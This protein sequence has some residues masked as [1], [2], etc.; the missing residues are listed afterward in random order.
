[1][2]SPALQEV[3]A[4]LA[5]PAAGD[6]SQYLFERALAAAGLDWRL[7]TCDIPPER[8]ADALRG[9]VAMGFRGCLV[10]G[11]LREPALSLV[12]TASP[13]AT[14]ARAVGLLERT[15]DGF[16][17]HMTD[18]RGVI[19]AV[20]AHLDP[21]GRD[22]LILGAGPTGRAVAL[23]LALAGAAAITVADEDSARAT[24]LVEDLAAMN[25]ARAEV[26]PWAATLDLP[27]AAAIVIRATTAPLTL[28][29][30]L[31][32]VVHVDVAAA[33]EP[34]PEAVAAGCC[35]VTGL[36]VR[37]VQAAIEF[38]ALTGIEADVE[39][40]REALDEYLS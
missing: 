15:G 17:G 28:A 36:E 8:L 18:G 31:P 23:E 6:P 7:I 20:R 27:A 21:A 9:A 3:V 38:Q 29:G 30:L 25:T 32:A 10:S 33:T 16:S 40:L 1:M 22:V 4:V 13:A 5:S 2:T 34:P 35:L 26:L 37:A 19:E 14:F 24:G 11:P 39:L 12:Q